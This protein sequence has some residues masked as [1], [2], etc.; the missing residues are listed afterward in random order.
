M[1]S[2]DTF[3]PSPAGIGAQFVSTFIEIITIS[4]GLSRPELA[5]SS[6]VSPAILSMT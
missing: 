5:G 4:D 6:P 2:V 3:V 1:A